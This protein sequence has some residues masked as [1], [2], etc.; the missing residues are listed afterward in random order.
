MMR[1]LQPLPSVRMLAIAI[2][3]CAGLAAGPAAAADTEM[4]VAVPEA[5]AANLQKQAGKRVALK[6]TSGQELEGTVSKVGT[7]AVHLSQLAGK[8]FFDA[9]VRL[10]HVT[11]LIVRTKTK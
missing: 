2:L 9:V 3:F 7:A 5:I 4:D 10:D 11:A 8:E 1:E 6:L